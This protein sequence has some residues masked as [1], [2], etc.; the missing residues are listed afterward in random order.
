[1][2]KHQRRLA[3]TAA[4]VAAAAAAAAITAA[5]LQHFKVRSA[6]CLPHQTLCAVVGAATWLPAGRGSALCEAAGGT[7]WL[8]VLPLPS[9]DVPGPRRC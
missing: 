7:A 6:G 1:M 3:A 8:A 4:A 5:P 2:H 9:D